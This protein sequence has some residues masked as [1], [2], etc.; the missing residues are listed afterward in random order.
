[1]QP[2]DGECEVERQEPAD[3]GTGQ[4]PTVAVGAAGA[5]PSPTAVEQLRIAGITDV[6][7]TDDLYP[8]VGRAASSLGLP[9]LD[10]LIG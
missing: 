2:L 8:T 1:M 7:D 3:R 9:A 6:T 4:R 10:V 5:G